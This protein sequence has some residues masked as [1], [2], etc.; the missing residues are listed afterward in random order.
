MENNKTT[1]LTDPQAHVLAQIEAGHTIAAAAAQAGVHRNTVAYWLHI[2]PEFHDRF[3]EAQTTRT[4]L[5][6]AEAEVRLEQAYK[7]LDRIL[8]N[9]ETPPPLIVKVAL[10]MIDRAAAPLPKPESKPQPEAPQPP[11]EPSTQNQTPI[12]PPEPI[13]HHP[14]AIT[15]AKIGRNDPCPCRSGRKFK[16]CCLGKLPAAVLAP[17]KNQNPCTNAQTPKSSNEKLNLL[18]RG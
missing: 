14:S 16:R 1:T 6:R 8:A 2:S 17:P 11:Q 15:R 12:T 10:A 4:L 5:M 9:P 7:A 13:T 18:I 3:E